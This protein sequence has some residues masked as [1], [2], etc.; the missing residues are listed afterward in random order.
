MTRRAS[1]YGAALLTFVAHAAAAQVPDWPSER[2][3][4]PLPA[5]D[6]KFPR[7]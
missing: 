1:W 2:P 4:R 6:V 3:P 5:R 7:A